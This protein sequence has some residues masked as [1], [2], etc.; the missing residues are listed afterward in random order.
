MHNCNSSKATCCASKKATRKKAARKKATRKLARKKATR[1]KKPSIGDVDSTTQVEAFELLQARLNALYAKAD[2]RAG[3]ANDAIAELLSG[4]EEKLLKEVELVTDQ[5]VDDMEELA[6]DVDARV[7][8]LKDRVLTG[9][10]VH[11]Q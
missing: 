5:L 9:E 8:E 7:E 10:I 6:V 2:E 4:L 11:T 1:K 3:A